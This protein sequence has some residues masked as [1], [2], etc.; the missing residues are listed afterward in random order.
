[1]A[2]DKKNVTVS[3]KKVMMRFNNKDYLWHNYN[4]VSCNNL[5]VSTLLA[6]QLTEFAIKN[7][8]LTADDLCVNIDNDST[9]ITKL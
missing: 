5:T 3:T 6:Q 4:W 1:M 9:T 8:F 7:K 2:K